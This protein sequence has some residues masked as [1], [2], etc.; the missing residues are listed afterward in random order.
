MIEISGFVLR[1]QSHA[2]SRGDRLLHRVANYE[3]DRYRRI[4]HRIV[5]KGVVPQG[6]V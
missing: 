1:Y 3:M 5:V 4:L 6:A 2:D